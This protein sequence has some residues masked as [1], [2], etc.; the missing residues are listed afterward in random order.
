MHN[1]IDSWL[2]TC[3]DEQDGGVTKDGKVC[4]YLISY[5]IGPEKGDLVK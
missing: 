3:K 2:N 1:E 5:H 4:V